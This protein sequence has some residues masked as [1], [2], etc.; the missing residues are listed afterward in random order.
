MR[1]AFLFGSAS[2]LRPALAYCLVVL[3]FLLACVRA[4]WLA[5]SRGGSQPVPHRLLRTDD[6]A[7]RIIDSRGRTLA[8]SVESSDLS[9]SPHSMWISHTPDRIAARLG[10]L[11]DTEP[12]ALLE[13]MLPA[14]PRG[15][16]PGLVRVTAPRLL[17]FDERA[18][19]RVGRWLRTGV[20]DGAGRGPVLGMELLGPFEGQVYTLQWRPAETLS[21]A[22][23]AI[24][25]EG[26]NADR[27]R[28]WTRKL[29]RDLAALVDPARVEDLSEAREIAGSER[30]RERELAALAHEVIWAELMPSRHKIVASRVEPLRV[31]R[32]RRLLSQ[33]AVSPYQMQLTNNPTRSQ[34]VR[35]AGLVAGKAVEP[36]A[37]AWSVLGGWGV[38]GA[39]R[40]ERAARG[41]LGVS[42]DVD[43]DELPASVSRAVRERA[44]FH[45]KD[46]RARSGLELACARQLERPEWQGLLRFEAGTYEFDQRVLPRDRMNAF[47]AVRGKHAEVPP[48]WLHSRAPSVEPEVVTTIDSGLQRLLGRRLVQLIEDNEAALA[49]GILLDVETG[50]V[51]AVDGASAYGQ[52]SFLPLQHEFT[53]GSTFKAIIMAAALD[54]GHVKPTD[55]FPTYRGNGIWIAN[56]RGRKV[57]PINE[58]EGSPR[59]D[60][61]TATKGLAR[62]VNAVLVQIGLQVP[63][64]E[65]RERILALGYG[66]KPGADLGLE[67]GGYVAPLSRGTWKRAYTHA[68]VSF[69]HEISV[70]LWQH[71]AAIATLARRGE[72]RPLR[73]IRGVRQGEKSWRIL[74]VATRRA[75]GAPACE[76]VLEMLAEG[77]LTGT[78]RHVASPD[79]NPEFEYLGTKTGTTEK[80]L[81]EMCLHVELP[82]YLEH[83]RI[84]RED[85]SDPRG[86]CGKQCIAR[87]RGQHDHLGR[88]ESCYT[89]SMAALGRVH[90]SDRTILS[91]V[92]VDGP[93]GKAR[94]GSDVAGQ[95]A[96]DLLRRAFELPVRRSDKEGAD[97]ADHAHERL[98][99]GISDNPAATA[100]ALEASRMSIAG[101]PN[102]RDLPWLGE[103][104]DAALRHALED[105]WREE[106]EL[107]AR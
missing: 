12:G 102:E 101:E 68:S 21:R 96:I 33:E 42:T 94:F 53:P 8:L 58:A 99:A 103:G 7:S 75:V 57:R 79:Q 52:S 104:G 17:V 69:G 70:T 31:L 48:Y 76:Q 73:M 5:L 6:P 47:R 82:H 43:L 84:A 44:E 65:L 11:L 71:A 64:A 13:R 38:L 105:A 67:R 80:V 93:R 74:P 90:G 40:A 62:S 30:Q 46:W 2:G 25:L 66:E 41:E 59:E 50:D 91:L 36:G 22:A 72:F 106:V 60:T 77:A 18:A 28:V 97:T 56:E 63:A 86:K 9:I 100:A 1:S 24:H 20:V 98:A 81:S 4:G 88:R 85:P 35:E 95:A 89:S 87:L 45:Q 23:R 3:V 51:L 37:D 39:E 26:R 78:G 55:T 34:P 15:E 14:P 32:V 54:G 27:P 107:A 49:M 83:A 29:V 10:E 19:G 61:I 92:V 16:D